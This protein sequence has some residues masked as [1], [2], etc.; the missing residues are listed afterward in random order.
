MPGAVNIGEILSLFMRIRKVLEDNGWFIDD[1]YSPR[2]WGGALSPDEVFISAILVQQTRWVNA[3]KALVRLREQGLNKLEK[4]SEISVDE[5]SQVIIGVN[6]RFTKAKRLINAAKRV[7]ELGGL[8]GLG[9]LSDEETRSILLDIDG[10]GLE[11]ADSIALFALNKHTIPVSKYT[12]TVAPRLLGIANTNGYERLRVLLM[13]IL[14]RRLFDYKLFH[15]GIVTV[16]KVWCSRDKPRCNECPLR[17]YCN[18]GLA[19]SRDRGK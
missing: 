10:V 14:P 16:G 7:M 13:G 12:M 15:A 19:F 3:V 9:R 17:M 6:Y 5:L 2:W 1:E 18:S 8:E 11:T 4:L